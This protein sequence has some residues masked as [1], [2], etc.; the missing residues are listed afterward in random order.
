MLG[1]GNVGER[2]TVHALRV[3]RLNSAILAFFLASSNV[4]SGITTPNA[5]DLMRIFSSAFSRFVSRKRRMS[6]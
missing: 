5:S 1:D 4:T 6:G 3:I 2:L